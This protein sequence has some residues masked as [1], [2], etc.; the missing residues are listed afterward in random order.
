MPAPG[1]QRVELVDD[2]L[3][4]R[5]RDAVRGRA[6]RSD[7]LVVARARYGG[8]AHHREAGAV[9]LQIHRRHPDAS[10][11]SEFTPMPLLAIVVLD[12]L[13][14]PPPDISRPEPVAF[15]ITELLM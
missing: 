6:D 5:D 2:P 3:P 11:W 9:I 14:K 13:M 1:P 15:V 12:A 10:G 4:E 7:H 8:A